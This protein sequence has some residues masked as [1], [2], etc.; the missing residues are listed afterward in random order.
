MDD[1]HLA[2]VE[3]EMFA[4]NF[5]YHGLDPAKTDE[6]ERVSVLIEFRGHN[7]VF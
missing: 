3:A 5:R 1:G 6:V 2:K 4:V 7:K